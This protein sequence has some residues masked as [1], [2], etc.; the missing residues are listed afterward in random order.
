MRKPKHSD[1]IVLLEFIQHPTNCRERLAAAGGDAQAHAGQLAE[2]L[3]VPT[4]LMLSG[5]ASIL[6]VGMG[7]RYAL[8]A[9][10]SLNLDPLGQFQEPVLQLDLQPRSGPV[11]MQPMRVDPEASIRLFASDV[12]PRVRACSPMVGSWSSWR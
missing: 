8:P 7:L 2:G 3:G 5:A 12:I 10:Q 9:L 1:L 11:L 6:G 4:A